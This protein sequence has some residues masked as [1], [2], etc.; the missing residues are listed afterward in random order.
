M[1]GKLFQNEALDGSPFYWESGPDGVLLLHGF[2][3]TT[4]EVR[5]LGRCLFDAGYTVSGPLLPGHGTTPED[6]DHC[7]WQ[8]WTLAAEN[9]YQEL[10]GNCR[11]VW[12]GGESMG[13]LLALHL[14]ARHP[15]AAGVLVYSPALQVPSLRHAR[16][17]APFVKQIR[18]NHMDESM[19]WKGYTVYP[20]RAAIQLQRLQVDVQGLLPAITQPVIIF[21]GRLDRTINPHS[22]EV[23][24]KDIRSVH[25][26]LVWMERSNHCLILDG[27]LDAITRD[28]LHFIREYSP[29]PV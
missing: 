25:K 29:L 28:T 10:A 23:I 7:R 27:E 26:K 6:L 13:A 11:R 18:K 21:Q 2:T 14:A 22:G 24:M 19:P 20:L 4:T 5:L 17:I 8:D 9:A 3:A 15:E 16:V 1:K 12:V